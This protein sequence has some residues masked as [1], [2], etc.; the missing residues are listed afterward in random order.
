[1]PE[2]L[3]SIKGDKNMKLLVKRVKDWANP[4]ENPELTGKLLKKTQKLV[5][6]RPNWIERKN[7]AIEKLF[8]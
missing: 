1:M 6:S 3:L 5:N 8:V 2:T 7:I 4:S